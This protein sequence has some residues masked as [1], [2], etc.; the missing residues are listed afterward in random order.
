[1]T[2]YDLS[3][4][5]TAYLGDDGDAKAQTEARF[6]TPIGCWCVEDIQ[7]FSTLFFLRPFDEPIND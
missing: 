4:A 3:V 6:G 5:I 1:M 7:E 2:K